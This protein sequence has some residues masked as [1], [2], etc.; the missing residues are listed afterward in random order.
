MA[1]CAS[2]SSERGVPALP[3]GSLLV[4]CLTGAAL[5][6]AARGPLPYG[7]GSDSGVAEWF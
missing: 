5:L 7:R 2:T 4:Y 1:G 6:K 3:F